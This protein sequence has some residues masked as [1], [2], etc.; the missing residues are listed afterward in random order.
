MDIVFTVIAM[1]IAV[2]G[3]IGAVV[4]MLPGPALSL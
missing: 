1:L 3:L 4:P 2:L